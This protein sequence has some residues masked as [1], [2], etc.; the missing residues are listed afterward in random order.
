M[1]E[2]PK[3]MRHT[4]NGIIVKFTSLEAGTVV[5]QGHS[6]SPYQKVGYYSNEWNTR[7]FKDYKP[8]IF[9]TKG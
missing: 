1:S 2:Y 5:G 9:K 7:V 4:S 8:E 3:L 6:G